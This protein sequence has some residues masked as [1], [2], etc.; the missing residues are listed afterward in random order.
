MAD[1]GERKGVGEGR[2]VVAMAREMVIMEI[3]HGV[4]RVPQPLGMVRGAQ[5]GG[6][7]LG[8]GLGVSARIPFHPLSQ[9]SRKNPPPMS[10]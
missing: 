1:P 9:K 2:E 3:S 4:H 7:P 6:G 10:R 8:V 5:G